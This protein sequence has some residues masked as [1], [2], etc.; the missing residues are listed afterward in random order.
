MRKSLNTV[1]ENAVFM[2]AGLGL[3][4][5]TAST[6]THPLFDLQLIFFCPLAMIMRICPWRNSSRNELMNIEQQLSS[7]ISLRGYQVWLRELRCIRKNKSE[8]KLF[9]NKQ[10]NI[11]IF[12]FLQ[13]LF[14]DIKHNDLKQN[15]S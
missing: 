12:Q 13:E 14:K 8:R 11:I 10:I 4:S 6:I 1:R 2:A 7:K 15:N 3:W 5:V 9:R